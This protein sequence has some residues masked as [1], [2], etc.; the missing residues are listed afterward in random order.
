MALC[1]RRSFLRGFQFFLLFLVVEVSLATENNVISD[2][3]KSMPF[4]N[5]R[6]ALKE[7][8]A[9]YSKV[10]DVKSKNIIGCSIKNNVVALKAFVDLDL[11]NLIDN[12]ETLGYL[13]SI[14]ENEWASLRNN[15]ILFMLS[16]E[17]LDSYWHTLVK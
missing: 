11:P 6:S 9:L 7:G 10:D 12:K 14:A 8:Y 13:S 3:E 15:E 16:C 5:Y 4:F 1:N 17:T 2:L